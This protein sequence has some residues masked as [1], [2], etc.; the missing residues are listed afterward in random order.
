MLADEMAGVP[1]G[2]LT[3]ILHRPSAW[4]ETI[5]DFIYSQLATWR[6]DPGRPPATA[7]TRLTAQLCQFLN[8]AT[9]AA[10]LDSVVFQSEVP[11]PTVAG[12]TLDLV[13]GPCGC[14]IWID[15]RRHS[16]Y[17]P[18]LPIECKRLPTPS[19]GDREKREYLHT[20][21]RTTGGVQRFKSSLHGSGHAVGAMIGYVQVG[22]LADWIA[23]INAWV[24]VLTRARIVGWSPA[25]ALGNGANNLGLRTAR[26]QSRNDRA[27]ASPITLHHLWV[28]M[29]S[30]A[31]PV[32]VGHGCD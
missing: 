6:D 1:S 29:R 2:S 28:D 19:S 32:A 31:E 14:V 27:G 4:L 15:G 11:D 30:V 12:R 10:G 7:E 22:T 8:S 17:D 21:K 3:P 18:I 5:V 16:L 26:H 25:D 13:P 20:Q 23:R 9:R 24:L